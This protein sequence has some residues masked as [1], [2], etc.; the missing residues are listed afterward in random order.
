MI[1]FKRSKFDVAATV[2]RIEYDPNRSAFIALKYEDGESV[3]ILGARLRRGY[4]DRGK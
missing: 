1:D 3:Y 2:Q 4:C